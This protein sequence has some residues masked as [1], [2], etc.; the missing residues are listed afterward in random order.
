[1]YTDKTRAKSNKVFIMKI[2]PWADRRDG[3]PFDFSRRAAV[4]ITH[5][6]DLIK[7]ATL[8]SILIDVARLIGWVIFN[9]G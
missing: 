6:P 4:L 9:F 2:T 7:R 5:P 3:I 8:L 1:M